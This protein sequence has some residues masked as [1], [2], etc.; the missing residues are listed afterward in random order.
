M[1]TAE[2]RVEKNQTKNEP[3]RDPHAEAYVRIENV[4]KRFGDFVAVNNVSLKIFKGEIFCL[5]GGSG[6]GKSTLLRMMAGFE[7]LSSGSIFLDGQDM[8]GVPP[9]ER[10]VNMMFQSYALFPHMTVEK[11]I[12]F[13]L[14]QEKGLSRADIAT[15]VTDILSIVKLDAFAAR[16]PHQLS[17]G[18]RQRVALARAL[19]KRP[20][21]L[22][23][24]E[25]LGALDKKLREATQF[26]LINIQEQLGVTF[27]VVTHDQEESMTLASRIG[28][29]NRGEIVQIG[30]PTEIYEFP[31]NKFVADFIGSVNMF[32]GTM[33]ED[34][35]DHVRIQS[36]ELGG[37]I[38]VDHGIS[39][40]PGAIV[41]TAI[42]PEKINILRAPPAET[43]ENCVKG[44]VKEIA[45]MGDVSI[46][47]VKIDTGKIV[48]VTLPNVERMSDDERILWDET[49]WLTWHGSS[50]VVVT[51]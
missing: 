33:I 27:I 29:M 22:L 8:A 35:P 48:R 16:R 19:V 11:N 44:T 17:G 1:L 3:W 36:D 9:Y 47:L 42:R 26:E 40:A 4:T 15:R 39:A 31:Q 14:E 46:Y 7:N 34:L 2:R 32:E 12:A 43:A 51:Q 30:T 38:Y 5:L 41:Y 50:P 37:I 23:L 45:Y 28:V 6:C 20:K 18:Q 10:P 24:D 25:P 21:L 49:V 13:G